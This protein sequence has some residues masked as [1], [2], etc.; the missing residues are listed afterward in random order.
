MT[1]ENKDSCKQK[2]G[3][4]KE[5]PRKIPPHNKLLLI[6]DSYLSDLECIRE[7]FANVLPM[8]REQDKERK[9]IVDEILNNAKSDKKEKDIE[10]ENEGEKQ[11]NGT[12]VTLSLARSDLNTVLSNIRKMHRAEELFKQQTTVSLISRFDEF[13]GHLLKIVLRIHPEWLSSSEKTITYRELVGLESIESA[14]I[15]LIHKEVE[16]LLRGSHEEQ[17]KFIDE[18]L[19]LG[20]RENFSRLPDFLEVAER[21]NLCVHTGGKVS[22]Q[23]IDRCEIFGYKNEESINVG[24]SLNIDANYFNNA[25]SLC[26]ELGLRISQAAYRR[27]FQDKLEAVDKSIN[28][29]AIKFLNS[30]D[31]NL[32]EIVCEFDL[33]IPEKFRSSDNEC[34]YFARINRAIAQKFAGKDFQAGLNGVHWQ[35]FHPKYSLALDV[36][37]EKYDSAA[38]AMKSS[39][40]QDSV[41]KIGFRS[42]PLFKEFRNTDIFKQT[43]QEIYEEEYVPDPKK[44]F[45]D[46]SVADEVLLTSNC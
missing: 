10:N 30:G 37:H 40:I 15:G 29:L 3:A 41:G 31:Y 13:L 32:A 7:M 46:E 5:P 6:S 44:D 1:E 25:F 24:S 14:I 36:L 16:T 21:R 4:L 20:T 42:W 34:I 33:G 19:K 12:R 26:F 43:Y 17:I 38:E 18:K 22:Q 2:S 39:A 35:A 45:E 8:L 11:E 27:L 9:K 23:Y 28:N